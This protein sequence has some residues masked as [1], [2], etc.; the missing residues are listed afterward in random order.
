MNYQWLY[1]LCNE[2][3]N[4][5]TPEQTLDVRDLYDWASVIAW[6]ENELNEREEEFVE[7]GERPRRYMRW[8]YEISFL[9]I[10]NSRED[11]SISRY[12]VDVPAQKQY[13]EYKEKS[14]IPQ[15][16]ILIT[17]G[18]AKNDILELFLLPEGK[19]C[20]MSSERETTS[21]SVSGAEHTY[22]DVTETV[23]SDLIGLLS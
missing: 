3:L 20:Y 15:W 1:D 18:N 4:A 8:L 9:D 17:Y 14:I 10:E 23:I 11:M 7:S 12:N 16:S 13:G 5:T 21:N 2:K 22:P 6:K 19:G